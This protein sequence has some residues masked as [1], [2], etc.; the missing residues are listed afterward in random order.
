MNG[1]N[2]ILETK[3]GIDLLPSLEE[4]LGAGVYFGHQKRRWHPKI[5]PYL[6]EQKGK[7]HIFDLV[8]T[9]D[10]LRKAAEFLFNLA[11]QG[12]SVIFVGTKRQ[13]SS[14]IKDEALRCGAHF[15]NK[16]WLG[17]TITNFNSVKQKFSRLKRIETGLAKGGQ[18]ENY[19]KKEKLELSREL[20]KLE[21]GIGGLKNL[22]S[23]PQALFVVDIKRE[24]TAVKEAK[25]R[26]VKVVAVVDSN[27][28]PLLVDFPIPGNDDS[29][30]SIEILT[31]VISQAVKDG[32]RAREEG[33]EK[34]KTAEKL[35]G[36]ESEE[37]AE[38][39]KGRKR[40]VKEKK[41]T[42]G[43]KKTKSAEKKKPTR[44][45]KKAAG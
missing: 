27:S 30:R 5:A 12:G 29:A 35:T 11:G 32:Y 31:Q 4:L 1:N 18:F 25:S 34:K 26:G 33:E 6:F 10:C 42:R 22:T 14:V 13:A 17:G 3:K 38:K 23:I 8:R 45:K 41:G 15:V 7:V 43:A 9:R 20:S 21:D 16:R 2:Q 44:G 39:K 37:T 28:S 24:A 40:V 36:G 19:T